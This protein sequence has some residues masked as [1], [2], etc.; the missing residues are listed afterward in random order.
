MNFSIQKGKVGEFSQK[1]RKSL[2]RE[3]KKSSKRARKYIENVTML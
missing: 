3:A 1:E 2:Q